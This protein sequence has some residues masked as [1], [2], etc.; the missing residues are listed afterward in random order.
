MLVT[1]MLIAGATQAAI[2]SPN[3]SLYPV[4]SE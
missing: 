3:S 4:L 1:I 2:L